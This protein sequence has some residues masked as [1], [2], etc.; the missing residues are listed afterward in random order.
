MTGPETMTK[1]TQ[2]QFHTIDAFNPGAGSWAITALMDSARSSA[3]AQ[4]QVRGSSRTPTASEDT[5]I[6]Y[7]AHVGR[8]PTGIR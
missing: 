1:L 8:A 3:R 4:L 5:K 7:G 6:N 2:D